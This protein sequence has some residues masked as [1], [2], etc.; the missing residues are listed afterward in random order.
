[1]CQPW[2][3]NLALFATLVGTESVVVKGTVAKM[4]ENE[5]R[6][7]R[8]PCVQPNKYETAPNFIQL[9]PKLDIGLFV[10]LAEFPCF[11]AVLA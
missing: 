10:D 4:W 8:L 3:A 2:P 9:L 5:K 7:D 11:Y 1:M 6:I